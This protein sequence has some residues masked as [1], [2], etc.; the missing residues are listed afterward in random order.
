MEANLKIRA[1]NG[2]WYDGVEI[3]IL[4]LKDNG[5]RSVATQILM[6]AKQEGVVTKP[7]LTLTKEQAQLLFNDL[8]HCGLRPTDGSGNSGELGATKYHLED[9]RKLVFSTHQYLMEKEK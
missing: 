5:T 9:M 2:N 1:Q 8:W 6:E 7:I 4:E 3:A